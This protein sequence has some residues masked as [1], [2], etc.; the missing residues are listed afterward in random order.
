MAKEY[1]YFCPECDRAKDPAYIIG[2]RSY[3]ARRWDLPYFMCGDCRLIYVDKS[4]IRKTVRAYLDDIKGQKYLPS[5][6]VIYKDMIGHLRKAVK[7]YCTTAGYKLA[8]FKKK[9]V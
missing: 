5:F 7:Y 2:I 6:P 8:K 4:L 3:S 1:L 9:L